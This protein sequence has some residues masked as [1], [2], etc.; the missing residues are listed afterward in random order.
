MRRLAAALVVAA[1]LALPAGLARADDAPAPP[2]SAA[3]PGA[4]VVALGAS[5]RAGDGT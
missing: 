2:P 5:S 3:R 1:G 4:L